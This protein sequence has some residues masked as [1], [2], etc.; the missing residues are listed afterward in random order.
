MESGF[1]AHQSGDIIGSAARL[2]LL[3][4]REEWRRTRYDNW[5]RTTSRVAAAIAADHRYRGRLDARHKINQK[6]HVY[7]E[8]IE[9]LPFLYRRR[10][11]RV[12]GWRYL[13]VSTRFDVVS[14]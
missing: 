14:G 6:S 3:V 4:G 10:Q 11:L 9:M 12:D 1:D 7:L 13:F 8:S 2:L 5:R